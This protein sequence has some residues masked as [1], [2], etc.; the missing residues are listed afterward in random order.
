[1]KRYLFL[2]VSFLFLLAFSTGVTAAPIDFDDIIDSWGTWCF[3]SVRISES[4]P[5]SYSHDL[6]DDVD[7]SA[8]Y[9]VTAATL[10]LD[11]ANDISDGHG[12][13]STIFGS[14][15]YDFRE[16]ISLVFDSDTGTF[17]EVGEVDNGQHSLGI[18][19]D[20]LNDDGF[21][22]VTVSVSNDLG[23]A[24]AWLDHSR[25][26]GTADNTAPVPE[27]ATILLMGIG[28]VGLAG[29]SRKK[30]LKR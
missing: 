23:T 9:L 26:Y 12:S 14:F 27:P 6:N 25:L 18:N 24:D 21:L 17:R 13:S 2:A 19:I 5:L 20:W 28:L 29:A 1:M 4:H 3:D 8:G 16:N 11:F 15:T 10:E 7:F 22:D 30:L